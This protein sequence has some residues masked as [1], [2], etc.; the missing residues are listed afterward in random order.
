MPIGQINPLANPYVGINVD[1]FD[2]KAL[3]SQQRH[4]QARALWT[5]ESQNI[6]NQQFQD[7]EARQQFLKERDQ[8]FRDVID[9]NAG[10]LSKGYQDILGAVEQSSLHQ[11]HNLNKRAVDQAAIQQKLATKYGS[12]FINTS[13][14]L[15]QS[16]Y[17]EGKWADPSSIQAGG[18]E[19]SAYQ[20]IAVN[21]LKDLHA[22]KFANSSGLYN[23][24]YMKLARNYVET[25]VLD[26]AMLDKFVNDKNVINTFRQNAPTSTIDTREYSKGQTYQQLFSDD[27]GVSQYLKGNALGKL[28]DDYSRKVQT[29]SNNYGLMLA[30][31]KSNKR[32][33][34]YENTLKKIYEKPIVNII[35]SGE[36]TFNLNKRKD[37]EDNISNLE[38]IKRNATLNI[39]DNNNTFS[40]ILGG[41]SQKMKD[42]TTKDKT[43]NRQLAKNFLEIQGKLTKDQIDTELST[44]QYL[45]KNTQDIY[46]QDYNVNK[47]LENLKF[48]DS[49]IN[50]ELAN[51]FFNKNKKELAKE[52]IHLATQLNKLSTEF[53]SDIFDYS[54]WG[55]QGKLRDFKSFKNKEDLKIKLDFTTKSQIGDINTVQGQFKKSVDLMVGNLGV[56]GFFNQLRNSKNENLI[57]SNPELVE[58]LKTHNVEEKDIIGLMPHTSSGKGL[59]SH[60]TI[61]GKRKEN[62]SGFGKNKAQKGDVNVLYLPNVVLNDDNRVSDEFADRL[63]KQNFMSVSSSG[64]YDNKALQ[65]SYHYKAQDKYSSIT[66]PLIGAL[67]NEPV[68]TEDIM[69][70]TYNDGTAGNVK[71]IR[72]KNG[73]SF[74]INNDL[75]HQIDTDEASAND[76][77][78]IE[79]GK[80]ITLIKNPNLK[81]IISNYPSWLDKTIPTSENIK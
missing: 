7:V 61:K 77:L 74:I 58:Y 10:N 43:F 44:L 11:Y 15:D 20:N 14:G 53:E 39:K 34:D 51:T 27:A 56:D 76:K 62:E 25:G 47:D 1:Y 49:N 63:L 59:V 36:E 52:G 33:L 35:P 66:I 80:Q 28:R 46:L 32:T 6:A 19:A 13:T 71:I 23:A 67:K 79:L 45:F 81:N 16:L 5:E 18:I 69:E 75:K 30:K 64:D 41:G 78:L 31:E 9:K 42:Y 65:M 24:G 57:A 50:M 2:K 12:K 72:Q 22:K 48:K 54:S 70:F 29:M 73:Y 21:M 17:N 38:N 60:L 37:I 3:Q 55:L 40:S 4:D 68:G 26:E 8:M